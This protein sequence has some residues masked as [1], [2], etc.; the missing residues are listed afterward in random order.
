MYIEIIREFERGLRRF[1]YMF[2]IRV[3]TGVVEI[4][5][6]GFRDESRPSR[7]HRNWAC[8]GRWDYRNQRDNTMEQPRVSL[9]VKEQVHAMLE[10]RIRHSNFE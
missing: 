8:S 5:F 3:D 9:D 6:D 10:A 2:Y 7:R 4:R 1:I